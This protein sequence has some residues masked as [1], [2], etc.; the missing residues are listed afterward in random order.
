LQQESG[1][2]FYAAAGPALRRAVM[3]C[4]PKNIF[5]RSADALLI[6]IGINDVGFASWA[7]GIILQ[8]PLLRSSASA[9]TPLLRWDY[10]VRLDAGPFRQA[11]QPVRASADRS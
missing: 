9:M 3:R 6:D 8:D 10:A 5:K 7:A 2:G 4:G 1:H 11:R